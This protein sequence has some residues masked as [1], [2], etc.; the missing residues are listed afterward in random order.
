LEQTIGNKLGALVIGGISVVFS[1]LKDALRFE[2]VNKFHVILLVAIRRICIIAIPD[3][4]HCKN[5]A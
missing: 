1:A 5:V 4:N 2:I 3:E